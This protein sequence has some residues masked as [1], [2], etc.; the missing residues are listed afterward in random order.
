MEEALT[1]QMHMFRKLMA[2]QSYQAEVEAV[3]LDLQRTVDM[4]FYTLDK[5]EEGG[6][7]TLSRDAQFL[8]TI[9]SMMPQSTKVKPDSLYLM[10]VGSE[11]KVEVCELDVIISYHFPVLE[12]PDFQPF[13]VV[14]IP[15]MVKS[16]FFVQI[17]HL[18]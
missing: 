13:Y 6:L 18:M 2:F 15:K 11:A 10:K 14:S 5:A 8:E 17:T 16:K 1:S 12:T 7:S 4:F 9:A 3:V